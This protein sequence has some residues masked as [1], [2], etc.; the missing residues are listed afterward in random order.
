M[1]RDTSP[2]RAFLLI[3]PLLALLPIGGLGAH[4][5]WSITNRLEA[6]ERSERFAVDLQHE[7]VKTGLQAVATDLCVLAQQNEL[8]QLLLKDQ[9]QARLAMAAE[10]L[11]L[12]RNAG[13]YDQIRFLNERGQEL[14]RVNDNRGS[15]SIVSTSALQDKS[16]R[17]Y[18][19]ETLALK[20]GQ[21]YVSPLDLNIEH[22]AIEKPF[23]PMIRVGTPVTDA[24]GQKRGIVLINVMAQRMLDQVKATGIVSVGQ[25]MMLN[26]AGYWLVTP[27]PPPGWGFMF[28]ERSDER[29]AVRYPQVW[30]HINQEAKGAIYVADGLFTFENYYPLAGLRGCFKR[31]DQQTE[32]D[33]GMGYRW[34]L[35]SHVPQALIKGWR[36]DALLQALIIGTLVLALLAIGTW[37]WLILAA[38]RRRHRANL[39]AL[40][41][42]DHLTGLANRV[43]FEERLLQEAERAKRHA[44]RFALLFLDLDGFKA[45]NDHCGHKTGDQV[46]IDVAQVLRSNCRTSDLAARQGGDEFV[47][48]LAEI[49]DLAAA[50]RVAEK[51]RV[52][53]ESLSWN[54]MRVG[55]SIGLALWPDDTADPETLMRLADDAMYQ[56][57]REGKNRIS[58]VCNV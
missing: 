43:T 50:Q 58:L 39:E 2:W 13:D 10:Y 20:P 28:A 26:N 1:T 11:A 46:L 27:N 55:A 48:L 18:F 5:L 6:V 16:N 8:S 3:F 21:I 57:K 49:D 35:V 40:A 15:P 56:A 17:Y 32:T 30:A 19:S 24:E 38:E 7:A 37:A 29:M 44:R 25:P 9:Q 47:V 45:I 31:R 33:S 22:G 54:E 4:A 14:V 41:R 42:F 53:I 12:A 51:L 23:K 52:H 36:H 34:I